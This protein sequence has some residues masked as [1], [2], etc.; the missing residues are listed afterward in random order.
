M[1]KDI[2]TEYKNILSPEEYQK[3]LSLF[4]LHSNEAKHQH[5]MYFDTESLRLKANHSALRIRLSDTY[6]HLT[7]KQSLTSAK[8]LEV[9]DK[10]S[11]ASAQ[12]MMETGQFQP[13][14]NLSA[15]FHEIGLDASELRPIGQFKTTRLEKNWKK[16]KLV[17]DACSFYTYND[18]E[19]ELEVEPGEDDPKRYLNEFLS[20]YHI[21]RRPSKPKIARMQLDKPLYP[22]E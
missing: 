5:N 12:A 7:Y 3:L 6:A 18:Y 20:S 14:A 19:L 4:D 8:S 17:L 1:H 10:V 16:Q 15:L 21:T 2:E 11:Q 22:F 13:G 9:T